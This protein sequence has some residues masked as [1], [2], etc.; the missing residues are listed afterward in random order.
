M[1]HTGKWNLIL[2]FT[3]SSVTGEGLIN[4]YDIRLK[5]YIVKKKSKDSDSGYLKAFMKNIWYW[6]NVHELKL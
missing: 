5:G 4:S 3:Q 6:T 1:S 2:H